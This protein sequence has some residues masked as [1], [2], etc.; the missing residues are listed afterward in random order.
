VT[1]DANSPV[2]NFSGDLMP[3]SAVATSSIHSATVSP[4]RET[5]PSSAQKKRRRSGSHSIKQIMPSRPSLTKIV[6]SLQTITSQH[7]ALQHIIN[8]LQIINA[9]EAI[10]A[11]LLPSNLATL[12]KNGK[13]I[14]FIQ[15]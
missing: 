12:K 4:I 6:L 9:R 5:R 7:Q 2:Q 10:V 14:L 8:A 1:E 11:A 13:V 15:L 3:S